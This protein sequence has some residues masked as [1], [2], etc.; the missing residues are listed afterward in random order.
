MVF[1]TVKNL[2]ALRGFDSVDALIDS[3]RGAKIDPVEPVLVNG[4]PAL[5]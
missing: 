4:K 1:P 5:R 3:R 2:E